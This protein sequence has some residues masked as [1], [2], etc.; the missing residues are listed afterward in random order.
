MDQ[1]VTGQ[2]ETLKGSALGGGE[3]GG[4]G[5]AVTRPASPPA[6]KLSRGDGDRGGLGTQGARAERGAARLGCENLYL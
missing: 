5:R 1:K 2:L 6:S 4:G 3:V